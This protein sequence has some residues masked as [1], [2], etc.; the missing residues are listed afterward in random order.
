MT[1]VTLE[2]ETWREIE[3][4]L[5][6]YFFDYITAIYKDEHCDNIEWVHNLIHAIEKINDAAKGQD[7]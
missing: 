2:N 3:N 4:V 6:T 7:C 1:K 5:D